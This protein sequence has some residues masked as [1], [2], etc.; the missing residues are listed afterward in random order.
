MEIPVQFLIDKL[1]IRIQVSKTDIHTTISIRSIK[2]NLMLQQQLLTKQL[3]Y[4]TLTGVFYHKNTRMS[5][6]SHYIS[7]GLETMF[8]IFSKIPINYKD[9]EKYI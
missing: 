7:T 6:L 5:I 2:K 3:E 1:D 4:E 9:L 8:P